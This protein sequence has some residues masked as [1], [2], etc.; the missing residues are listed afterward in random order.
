MNMPFLLAFTLFHGRLITTWRVKNSDDRDRNRS[1][2]WSE[3]SWDLLAL[4][5]AKVREAT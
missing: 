4:A 1:S 5:I 2:V 3:E